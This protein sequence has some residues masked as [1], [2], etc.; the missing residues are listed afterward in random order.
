MFLFRCLL[1]FS[2]VS[3]G[4]L[5]ILLRFPLWHQYFLLLMLALCWGYHCLRAVYSRKQPILKYSFVLI[6]IVL[7]VYYS[8][9][10]D[11]FII[12]DVCFIFHTIDLLAIRSSFW[13]KVN[14]HIVSWAL[15]FQQSIQINLPRHDSTYFQ[16][17]FWHFPI[18]PFHQLYVKC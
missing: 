16:A 5:S 1:Y 12:F 10:L 18:P 13:V 8:Q 14:F 4:Q 15:L 6:Q 11:D 17:Y 2:R 3:F 7:Q 9:W